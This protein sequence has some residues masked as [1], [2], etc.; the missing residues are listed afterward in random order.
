VKEK[1]IERVVF[2]NLYNFFLVFLF[3]RQY[4][5]I[6]TQ[7]ARQPFKEKTNESIVRDVEYVFKNR[8]LEVPDR[9]NKMF[10]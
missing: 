9:R 1:H 4:K 6:F 7:Q 2:K 10:V 5:K 3:G 8:N